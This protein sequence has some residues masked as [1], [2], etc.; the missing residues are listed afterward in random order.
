MGSSGL[1][2]WVRYGQVGLWGAPPAC[3]GRTSAAGHTHHSTARSCREI[4]ANRLGP[5]MVLKI[6]GL[7]HATDTLVG[8][9]MH[10]GI[11]GGERKRLT[12]AEIM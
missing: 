10:R 7:A 2:L 3:F 6:M 12:T 8:D 11:S 4:V 5:Q 9:E 1:G